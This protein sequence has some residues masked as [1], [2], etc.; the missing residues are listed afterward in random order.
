MWR[1]VV[2]RSWVQV[3]RYPV[4]DSWLLL[5]RLCLLWAT[6][7]SHRRYQ[8]AGSRAV[9]DEAWVVVKKRSGGSKGEGVGSNWEGINATHELNKIL[10]KSPLLDPPSLQILRQTV[11]RSERF[12][13]FFH[14]SFSHLLLPSVTNLTV[15]YRNVTTFESIIY[16]FIH[17]QE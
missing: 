3:L 10:F 13:H 1:E 12:H 16:H 2:F 14:H 11:E 4:D 8:P 7:S 9:D 15:V 6:V 17:Q 5:V